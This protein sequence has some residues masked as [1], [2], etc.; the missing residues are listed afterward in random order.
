MCH[1]NDL[2][3]G[4][5]SQRHL[6][7]FDMYLPEAVNGE[8]IGWTQIAWRTKRGFRVPELS[9]GKLASWVIQAAGI[10]SI[11]TGVT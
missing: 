8:R 2:A 10:G 6:S 3:C 5:E 4:R 11:S 1:H 7:Q 9:Q